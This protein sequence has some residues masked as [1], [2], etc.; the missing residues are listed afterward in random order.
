MKAKG[1]LH[2]DMVFSPSLNVL[3]HA[4]C[5][6]CRFQSRVTHYVCICIHVKCDLALLALLNHNHAIIH[7]S[8]CLGLA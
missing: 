4:C 3:V 1:V 7:R 6:V 8:V 2:F 5:D